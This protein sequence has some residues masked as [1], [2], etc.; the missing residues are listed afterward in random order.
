M[1][2]ISA[3]V[4]RREGRIMA[5]LVTGG[6]G[7]VGA[8]IV[9]EL[10]RAGHEVVSYD[11]APADELVRQ[12][13]AEWEGGITFV[14][15]DIRDREGVAGLANSHVIDKVIHAATYTVNQR[16]L[17]VERGR[18]VIGINV[19]GLANVLELARIA[20]VR[21]F[22][23][24]SSGAA[25]GLAA[26]TDQTYSEDMPAAPDSMYGITKY[27]G[28]LITRRYGELYGFEQASVR[29]ST[30]YGPMERVTGHRAVMS[31]LYQ[32]TG[33]VARGEPLSVQAESF[34]PDDGRDY[35]YAVDTARG[36]QAILDAP[37]LPHDLYNLTTGVWITYREILDAI[38]DL[39]PR[40][41][42]R[43]VSAADTAA[44]RARASVPSRGPLSAHRLRQDLG[45]QPEFDLRAGLADYLQWRRE[46]EFTA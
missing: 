20:G 30:P 45:W 28:E 27:A 35:T 39:V 22:V 5:T 31:A 7:F 46:S 12:F 41:D 3:T 8:N 26:G 36:L 19:E 1:W 38:S 29:L 10:A 16:D 17:E 18:D 21:R 9:R 13:V 23:Y 42:P 25:Y 6:T 24:V 32:W 44:A 40:S 34:A 11:V 14:Q 43:P 15:G 4:F 33:Q 2:S 37:E